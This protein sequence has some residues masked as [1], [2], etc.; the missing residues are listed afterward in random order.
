MTSDTYTQ[1]RVAW[2]VI[3][4]HCHLD[5]CADLAA[6]LDHDLAAVITVATEHARLAP[7]LRLAERRPAH[8]R[9]R[10]H[11]PERGP[12]G[13]RPRSSR[14]SRPPSP[15]R[16][17]SASARPASTCT[18]T[19]CRSRSSWRASAGR[20]SWPWGTTCRWCSTC[21]TRRGRRPRLARDGA[22]LVELGHRRGVL[23]CTNGH[24]GLIE[25]ALDLG[26]YVSFAGN[27]TYPKATAV[28]AAAVTVPEDRLL[29][30]TDAPY[31]A[32]V[33]R[34]GP[35]QPAGLRALHGRRARAAAGRRS[36]RRS[37]GAGRQRP[38]ALPAYLP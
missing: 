28:R 37:S 30:E 23:H 29:V 32:P 25:V 15:T 13:G 5:R 24:P 26:W 3:D 18:G 9:R 19:A 22:M 20:V 14:R 12:R 6:A 17:W 35:T 8:L 10:R 16:G 1:S 36:A 38:R 21:A 7:V 11:P 31:L 27:L 4:T 33:P 2:R 34:R